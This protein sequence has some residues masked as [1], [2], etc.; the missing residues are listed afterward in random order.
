VE[1]NTDTLSK[2]AIISI[3]GKDKH[4]L[5]ASFEAFMKHGHNFP[6]PL[7]NTET[8]V[9]DATNPETSTALSSPIPSVTPLATSYGLSGA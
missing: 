2:D 4:K 6:L 5:L 1:K 7:P 3:P 9:K 8:P